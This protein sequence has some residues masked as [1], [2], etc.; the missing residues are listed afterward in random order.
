[1]TRCCSIPANGAAFLLVLGLS[2]AIGLLMTL[3]IGRFTN[4][5]AMHIQKDRIKAHLLAVRLYRD[6]PAIVAQSY[7]RVLRH[8]LLYLRLMGTVL[9]LSVLPILVVIVV[10]DRYLAHAAILPGETFLLSAGVNASGSLDAISLEVP[11]GLRVTAPPVRIA[12]ERMIVWRV[13]A[14]TAGRFAVQVNSDGARLE[15]RVAVS[16][17]L[18][19]LSAERTQDRLWKRFFVSNEPAV[20]QMSPIQSITVA[21][22]DR[23]IRF[24]GVTWDWIWLFALMSTVAGFLFKTILRVEI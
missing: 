2:L 24:A 18:T 8:V 23:S 11:P 7:L 5:Q 13:L 21:Y 19:S 17:G 1:M 20:P 4:Q 6:Q 12:A 3:V 16:S 14:E 22:P 15:K 10:A 9:V